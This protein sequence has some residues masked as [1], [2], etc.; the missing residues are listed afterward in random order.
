MRSSPRS[1]AGPRPASRRTRA[2]WL[3][4]TAKHRAI[5]LMRRN[6]LPPGQVRAA[7]ARARLGVDEPD[8][9]AELDDEIG[10]D[11]LRLMFTC[12]HPVLAIEA[13]VAL[14][15]RMLGGLKTPEIARAFLVPERDRRP[16]DL[17]READARRRGRAVRGARR[18]TSGGAAGLRAGG[19]LPDLQRGLL[20]DGG[21]RLDAAGA[22]RGGAAA[23]ARP[24]RPRAR[25]ARGA[26]AGRADGAAGVAP[27]GADRA[28]TASRSCS[29][30]R[31]AAAGTGC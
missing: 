26:R 14:T 27:G 16:A 18:A 20:R 8:L 2:A 30:T 28:R 7:R 17:A 21:R 15:L 13:R 1:S 31:T 24:R 23:R 12:C 11:V 9:D 29:P 5:D 4:A 22:D 25:G 3:T 19:R 6:T 10:D